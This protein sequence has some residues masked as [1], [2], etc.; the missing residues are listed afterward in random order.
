M[1][2]LF[3][4]F[5]MAGGSGCGPAELEPSAPAGFTEATAALLASDV[6]IAPVS[7]QAKYRLAL[8]YEHFKSAGGFLAVRR[9]VKVLFRTFRLQLDKPSNTVHFV[10]TE[11]TSPDCRPVGQT[12][13]CGGLQ[14]DLP[15][16]M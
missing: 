14:P 12:S 10:L 4:F 6:G 11:L 16:I 8:A 15:Q 3:A 5:G 7:L 13:V 9:G 2:W 1:F